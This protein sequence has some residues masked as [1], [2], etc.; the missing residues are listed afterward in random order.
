MVKRV[1]TKPSKRRRGLL[2][3]VK[4]KPDSRTRGRAAG[5]E[6]VIIIIVAIVGIAV[7]A[8]LYLRPVPD[9]GIRIWLLNHAPDQLVV[10]NADTGETEKEL[11]IAD[12]LKQF[13]FNHAKDTAYIANVVDVSNRI[14]VVDTRSYLRKDQ[15][16]VDGVPQG[17]DIFPGDRYLAAI[18][19]SKTD[20]MAGGFDVLDLQEPSQADPQRKRVTYRERGLTLTTVIAVDDTGENVICLDAKASNVFIFNV[21]EQKLAR[22]IDI[23]AAPLGMLYPPQGEYFF[24][25]SIKDQS[26]TV[27]TKNPD[28]AKIEVVAKVET[29]RVRDVALSTDAKI[30]YAPVYERKDIAV[31]DLEKMEVVKRFKT[32]DGCMLAAASPLGGQLY[33]IGYDN[34]Q[35][36]VLDLAS[37]E[38]VRT[39]PVHGEFRDMKVILES[40]K[41]RQE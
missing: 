16:V 13:I 38:L 28:P 17:L 20:F 9:R 12:G 15:I 5:R 39:I 23:G 1:G 22:T 8:Y 7:F 19:G 18:M 31:V 27:L 24:I 37:G 4:K 40:E 41:P 30:L 2:S 3:A 34:G 11:L 6:L 26:V 29:G 14:T 33:A 10:V 35:V 21:A 32:P 25:C 36:F